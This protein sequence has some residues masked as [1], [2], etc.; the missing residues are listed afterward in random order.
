MKDILYVQVKGT[1]PKNL[2]YLYSPKKRVLFVNTMLTPKIT[3]VLKMPTKWLERQKKLREIY[4]GIHNDEHHFFTTAP[5]DPSLADYLT[6]VTN[7]DTAMRAVA[8]KEINAV[9]NRLPIWN[10]GYDGAQG[11]R[12][13]VEK[14]CR[15]DPANAIT[16]AADAHMEIKGSSHHGK[17]KMTGSST[18]TGEVDL[19][20]LVQY[21]RQATEWVYC[22]DL[23][24]PANWNLVRVPPT[25]A[26]ETTITGLMS[27]K[28]YFFKS[29]VISKFGPSEWSDV[30]T[31]RVK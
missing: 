7:F 12:R 4:D 8:N 29:R 27:G 9:D 15:L 10:I 22:A 25:L 2:K 3:V 21:T 24:D 14:L 5:S 30:I 13:Y 18:R 20:G 1:V 26:A 11:L 19:K 31:V 23:G 16:I 6:M 17:Q 28:E